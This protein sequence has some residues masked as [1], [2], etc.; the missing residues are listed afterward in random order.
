MIFIVFFEKF[1]ANTDIFSIIEYKISYWQKLYLV[2]YVEVCKNLEVTFYCSILIYSLFISLRIES[3][4]KS[5][6]DFKK[7]V[8]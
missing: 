8:M 1:I 6:L 5:V 7:V 3:N 4:R 2:I